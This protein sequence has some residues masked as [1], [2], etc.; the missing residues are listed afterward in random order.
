[1]IFL[2]DT[3]NYTIVF[4]I[5]LDET[6]EHDGRTDRQTD[7]Q[8]KLVWLLQRSSLRSSNAGAL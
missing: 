2:A 1:M 5:S 7:G 3:E 6:P 8:T 4:F